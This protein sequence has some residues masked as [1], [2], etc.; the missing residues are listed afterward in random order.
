M[1]HMFLQTTN[2]CDVMG[3]GNIHKFVC[4]QNAVSIEANNRQG[5]DACMHA[6]RSIPFAL[7]TLRSTETVHFEVRL[8]GGNS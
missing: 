6:L 1:H 7:R 4:Y 8:T 2:A 3:G 5:S